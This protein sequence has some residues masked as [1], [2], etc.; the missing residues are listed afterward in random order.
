MSLDLILPFLRP[1]EQFLKDDSVTEVMVNGSGLVFIER[2]GRLSPVPA[3]AV[4][5]KYLNVAVKN[6]ARLLGDD[7]SEAWPILDARLPDGSRV[8]AVCA[9]CSIGGTTLTIRKFGSRLFTMEHLVD[10]GSLDHEAACWL[11]DAVR[12]KKNILISG[13][14]G[15]GKTT[16]LGALLGEIPDDERLILIEDT[17][18]IRLAKP[19]LVRFEARRAVAGLP[20]VT[21]RDLVKTSLRHRPDRILVGEVRGGEAFDLLQALNTGHAGAISTLHASSAERALTR[22]AHCIL[23]SGIALSFPIACS[24]IADA[25]DVVVQIEREENQ[26]I[27]TEIV[28]TTGFDPGRGAFGV[29]TIFGRESDLGGSPLGTPG[30]FPPNREQSGPT[31]PFGLSSLKRFA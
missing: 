30:S 15:A 6:I 4:N 28:A 22:L 24:Q 31:K 21:I 27:V 14:T 29:R 1:I 9:P 19:N 13:G 17:A 23:Q 20:E 5:P 3:V 10:E 26:R 16:L 7:I 11:I 25:I 2:E 8:A 18:E 12:G